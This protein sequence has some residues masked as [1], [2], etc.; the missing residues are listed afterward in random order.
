[1]TDGT[2]VF[3][4][5]TVNKIWQWKH[6]HKIWASSPDAV[7]PPPFMELDERT[8]AWEAAVARTQLRSREATAL[9]CVRALISLCDAGGRAC[10]TMLMQSFS[11]MQVCNLLHPTASPARPMHTHARALRDW[12]PGA[13]PPAPRA[14]A[15]DKGAQDY[16]V[17]AQD[18][19]FYPAGRH[20]AQGA[21]VG[22]QHRPPSRR[23]NSD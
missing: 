23:Q 11:D 1:M 5:S 7:D 9:Q 21:Q 6:Q 3:L 15:Q 19:D 12:K 22:K 2:I 17:D 10:Q 13:P 16:D 14:A 20:A 4:I 18:E 8:I